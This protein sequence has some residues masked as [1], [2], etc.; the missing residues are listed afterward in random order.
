MLSSSVSNP[1]SPAP[2]SK[3]VAPAPADE[4]RPWHYPDPWAGVVWLP[5][6]R[7]RRTLD[8]SAADLIGAVSRLFACMLIGLSLFMTAATLAA[9]AA[10]GLVG[11]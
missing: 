5:A 11:G 4:R 8:W 10:G 6:R 3:P 2:T 7:E 1:S 9:V